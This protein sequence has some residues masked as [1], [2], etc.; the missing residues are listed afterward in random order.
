[1]TL[2]RVLQQEYLESLAARGTIRSSLEQYRAAEAFPLVDK[3]ILPTRIKAAGDFPDLVVGKDP[4]KDDTENAIAIHRFLPGL[5]PSDAA[6]RRL[7]A[8]LC[9][10]PLFE[11]ARKRW[12]IPSNNDK[13]VEHVRT[14][15]FVDGAGLNALRRNA[16]ARLW[17]AASLTHAPW[18]RDGLD[19]VKKHGDEY[20]FT[21]I[22]LKNQDIYQG[23]VERLFGTDTRVL[24]AALQVIGEDEKKRATSEFS[25]AFGKELNLQAAFTEWG[26]LKYVDLLARMR[27]VATSVETAL[28]GEARDRKKARAR[29]DEAREKARRSKGSGAKRRKPRAA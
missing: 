8:W 18:N 14:H 11:Y 23:L 1:M 5:L 6:D 12:E 13:A 25:P 24:I 9:H 28:E 10:G 16:I 17:W 26:S 7:W 21:R 27:A 15:W 20:F 3:M 19:G 2:I 29:R 22:L 4:P